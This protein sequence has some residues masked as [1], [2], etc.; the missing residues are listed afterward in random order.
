MI[1]FSLIFFL[2]ALCFHVAAQTTSTHSADSLHAAVLQLQA[3]VDHIKLNLGRSEKRFKTGIVVSTIGYTTVITGGLMLGRK[4]DE[5][6]KALLVTGGV[7]GITGTIL[8]VD[9]F[10][11][12][13]IASEKKQN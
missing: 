5:L 1:R 12:L 7:T 3:D 11:F 6:G 9:A 4:H 13:G 2:S 10:R 8:L